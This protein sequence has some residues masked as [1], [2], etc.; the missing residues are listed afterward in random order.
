MKD[1]GVTGRQ[2]IFLKCTNMRA[3][4]RRKKRKK[5]KWN[6]SSIDDI[7]SSKG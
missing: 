2:T 5:G 3:T 7:T 6:K 4:E 1:K